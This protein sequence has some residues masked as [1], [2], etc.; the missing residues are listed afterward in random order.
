MRDCGGFDAVSKTVPL[1]LW[2]GSLPLP[3]QSGRA[4]G[5]A[6]DARKGRPTG[7]TRR[8]ISSR[9]APVSVGKQS[10]VPS[11]PR[12]SRSGAVGPRSRS[13]YPS[14]RPTTQPRQLLADR[15][16]DCRREALDLMY[17]TIAGANPPVSARRAHARHRSGIR[18]PADAHADAGE[19]A[20]RARPVTPGSVRSGDPPPRPGGG[21]SRFGGQG[22]ASYLPM[23][24]GPSEQQEARSLGV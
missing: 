24:C 19:L 5:S 23:L 7:V 13:S 17:E 14:G 12:S 4:H 16:S 3:P 11:V 10:S 15:L 22:C 18:L 2:P 6:A 9:V 8:A 20:R 1:R 21:I